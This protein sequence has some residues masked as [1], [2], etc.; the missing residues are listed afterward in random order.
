MRNPSFLS[1]PAR[2]DDAKA[3]WAL[4]WILGKMEGA[5]FDQ[6]CAP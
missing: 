1:G 4:W 5:L 6:R 2:G 3:A